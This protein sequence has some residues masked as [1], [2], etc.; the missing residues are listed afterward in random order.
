MIF[1][2]FLFNPDY[3]ASNPPFSLSLPPFFFSSVTST[4]LQT[5]R[6]D[7]IIIL[8]SAD[9]ILG[10]HSQNIML[11]SGHHAPSSFW[12]R[13]S[14][15]AKWCCTI[16]LFIQN[17]PFSLHQ[18]IKKPLIL[19][20]HETPPQP[21]HLHLHFTVSIHNR[22]HY[23]LHG[24]YWILYMRQHNWWTSNPDLES[25]H[26]SLQP[27]CKKN[28]NGNIVR[29]TAFLCAAPW[30]VA[31][32]WC[33]SGNTVHINQPLHL[34]TGLPGF[35]HRWNSRGGHKGEAKLSKLAL[36]VK[37]CAIWGYEI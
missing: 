30:H 17:S 12:N 27:G 29:H 4:S 2:F 14:F 6:W 20:V 10:W 36:P 9:C 37:D 18:S 21:F 8:T 26:M 11:E 23:G 16:P 24:W 31:P 13:F 1:F 19:P 3:F 34:P 33:R 22:L 7:Q 5:F 35:W 15:L 32:G 28:P 25:A